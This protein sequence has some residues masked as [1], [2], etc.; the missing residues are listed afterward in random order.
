MD[1]NE[2]K[3]KS[4]QLDEYTA[5]HAT[6]I[7]ELGWHNDNEMT[8]HTYWKELP[9]AMVKAIIN[10]HGMPNGLQEWTMHAEQQ[11]T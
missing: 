11:H 7:N 9:D 4:R 8:C 6:L 5:N 3:M 1:I 10:Q 2:L